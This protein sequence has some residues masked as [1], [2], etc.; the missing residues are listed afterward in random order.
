MI[1]K[2]LVY[3]LSFMVILSVF[4]FISVFVTG[5]ALPA[6]ADDIINQAIHSD[7]VDELRG[8]TGFANSSGIWIWYRSVRPAG[9]PKGDILLVSGIAADSLWWP[10][11]FVKELVSAGYRVILFDNRCTGMSD[12][13]KKYTRWRYTLNEMAGDG[14]AVLDKLGIR[15]AHVLGVSMG[16]MIAQQMAISYP[17]R[18]K[19]LTSV[20][21][22]ADINDPELPH[23]P[24]KTVMNVIR[25]SC[26][27][28]IVESERNIIKLH[29]AIWQLFRNEALSAEDIRAITNRV[30]L[31]IRKRRG[32]NPLALPQQLHAIIASGSRYEGLG[33][34]TMPALFIHG[35]VDPLI[36]Y[37]HGVKCSRI[38]KGS[39]LML[40]EGMGH[41]IPCSYSKT[42]SEGIKG[43]IK[44]SPGVD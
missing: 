33:K 28:G 40:V 20:M 32:F 31:D 13:M 19:T 36:P 4:I 8:E 43:F 26:R 3:F 27:Y 30:L 17:D 23:M 38:V 37:G 14:I 2:I 24:W 9:V 39:L 5:P 6:V 22:S 7:P 35:K 1:K 42:V 21:S 10:P 16:G 34:I 41:D 15:E 25:I 11:C 12:W 18:V 29:L 44:K